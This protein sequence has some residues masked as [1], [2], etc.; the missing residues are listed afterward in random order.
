MLL[1]ENKKQLIAQNEND[2]PK[3]AKQGFTIGNDNLRDDQQEFFTSP[4]KRTTGNVKFRQY[5]QK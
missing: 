1:S 2:T 5:R 3:F 4:S